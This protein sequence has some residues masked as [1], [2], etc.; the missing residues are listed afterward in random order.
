MRDTDHS[1]LDG[2]DSLAA[3]RGF[4][5]YELGELTAFRPRA[6]IG[7]FKVRSMLA[8]RR[9]LSAR[10]TRPWRRRLSPVGSLVW[11]ELNGFPDPISLYSGLAK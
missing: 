2:A 10:S 7:R 8:V 4:W 5:T 9:Q 6:L 1:D 11:P 3:L